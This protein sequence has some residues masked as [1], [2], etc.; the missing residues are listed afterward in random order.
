M[1]GLLI[2]AAP[3]DAVAAELRRWAREPFDAVSRNCALSV[4]S[5]VEGVTGQH[6]PVGARL[7]T[8]RRQQE[9]LRAH[10]RLEGLA[11]WALQQL[12]CAETSAP[13]RGD[14]GL[15]ELAGGPTAA[16]CLGDSWAARGDRAVVVEQAEPLAAWRVRC[17]RP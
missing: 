4:L 11:R 9:L 12:G 10:G 16:I 14:V 1:A 7:F 5:Y 3:I 6:L 15:V 2:P 13:V 17:P 8:R